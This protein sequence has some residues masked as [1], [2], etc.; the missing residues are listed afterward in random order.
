ML[1]SVNIAFALLYF[2]ALHARAYCVM[3]VYEPPRYMTVNTAI[4]QLLE[5]EASRKEGAYGE[6]TMCVGIA[7]LGS[8]GQRIAAGTM[9]ELLNVDFG[10]PLHSL[11][12]AGDT[13]VIENEILA[14]FRTRPE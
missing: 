3:Q 9:A 11:I 4:E 2:L 14:Q 6:E 12:I 5:V 13:H 10:P 8:V 1:I 7:R